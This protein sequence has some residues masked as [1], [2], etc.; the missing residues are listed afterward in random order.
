MTESTGDPVQDM[1]SVLESV[2]QDAFER[3]RQSMK[4]ELVTVKSGPSLEDWKRHTLAPALRRYQRE[5]DLCQ[6]GMMEFAEELDIPVAVDYKGEIV[7]SIESDVVTGW[8][9]DEATMLIQLQMDAILNILRDQ[10]ITANH[11]G[12]EIRDVEEV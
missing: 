5:Y 7:I 9:E 4:D 8:N 12:C 6:A 10:G 2:A 1:N 11:M 3:G